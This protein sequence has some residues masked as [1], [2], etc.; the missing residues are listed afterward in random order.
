M[1]LITMKAARANPQTATKAMRRKSLLHQSNMIKSDCYA[2][3]S[4]GDLARL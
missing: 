3:E 2:V 1:I 4:K